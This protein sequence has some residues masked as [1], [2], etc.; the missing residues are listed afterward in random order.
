V[1]KTWMGRASLVLG[2]STW[3]LPFCGG[4]VGMSGWWWA[5]GA[6]GGAIALGVGAVVRRDRV[7][8]GVGLVLGTTFLLAFGALYVLMGGH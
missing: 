6:G 4:P 5:L 7:A 8:G 1:G 2:V 3:V